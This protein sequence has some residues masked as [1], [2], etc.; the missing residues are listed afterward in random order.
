MWLTRRGIL[1]VL[2]SLSN[3]NFSDD[4]RISKRERNTVLEILFALT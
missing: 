1:E 3:Y 2:I 4:F